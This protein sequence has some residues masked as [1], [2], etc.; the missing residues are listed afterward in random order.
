[1]L[2]YAAATTIHLIY[3]CSMLIYIENDTKYAYL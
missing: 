1:M 3:A 2:M